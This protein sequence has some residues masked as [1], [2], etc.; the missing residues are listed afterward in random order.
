MKESRILPRKH[1]RLHR[2]VGISPVDGDQDPNGAPV[3][4][5]SAARKGLVS[6]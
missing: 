5:V 4:E 1:V 6:L 3:Q 2:L